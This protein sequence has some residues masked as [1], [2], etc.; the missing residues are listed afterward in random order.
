[1]NECRHAGHSIES[2]WR[3]LTSRACQIAA[4]QC[5]AWDSAHHVVADRTVSDA[6]VLDSAWTIDA[7]GPFAGVRRL[8]PDGSYSCRDIT[9][10]IKR[11]I[12]HASAGQWI[13]P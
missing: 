6:M 1:M 3:V 4:R 5:R 12:P 13:A 10:L 9:A 11:T 7:P 2:S 8:T